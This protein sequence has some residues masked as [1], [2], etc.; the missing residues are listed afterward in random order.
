MAA[1]WGWSSSRIWRWRVAAAAA[2]GGA[3]GQRRHGGRRRTTI[4]IEEKQ[5]A[6][7]GRRGVE[8]H[9]WMEVMVVL[10]AG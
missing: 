4:E 9:W 6:A 10:G 1:A 8:W 2:I 3:E 5:Q 7:E